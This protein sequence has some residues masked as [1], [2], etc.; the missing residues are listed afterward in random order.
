MKKRLLLITNG[1]PFGQS[2]RG[3][4]SEE[5]KLLAEEFDLLVLAPENQEELLYP[6]DGILRIERYRYS[7]FRKTHQFRALPRIVCWSTLREACA[8][9]KA[10]R[11]SNP[12][13][14][15]R[16]TLYHR[17]NVWEMEEK[18]EKL[19]REEKIDIVYA[20]WCCEYAIAAAFLK[21]RFPKLK[22]IIRFH[23]MDLYNERAH[24][25]W[26]HF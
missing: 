9:A 24:G 25:N 23:G 17:F 10:H 8:L 20:Y 19:V 7:S 11:F 2:E 12:I 15:L 3:F 22:V 21:K 18:I 6:T 26:Q 4:L 14:D 1:F 5:A 16:Q 13:G